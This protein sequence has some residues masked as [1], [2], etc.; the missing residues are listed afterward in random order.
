MDEKIKTFLA[1]VQTKLKALGKDFLTFLGNNKIIFFVL[2]PLFIWAKF[3]DLIIAYLTYKTDKEI[4]SD[5][6]KND[7]LQDK[8]IVEDAKAN[9]L[10]QDAQD[11]EKNKTIVD[12]NWDIKK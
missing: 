4:G 2:I 6:K 8:I 12:E 1:I 7:I 9:A 10:V 11:Q 5:K 3:R